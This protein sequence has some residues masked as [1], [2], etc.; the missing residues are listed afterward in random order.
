MRTHRYES[1]AW[2]PNVI[3]FIIMLGLGGKHFFNAP[4]TAP[5]TATSVVT[6]ATTT[7]SSVISWSTMTP[8]YGVYHN[9]D[10]SRYCCVAISYE[11]LD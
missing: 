10:A 7:A 1:A 2:I 3:S 11:N 9:K 5:V 8:D 4:P 6:F